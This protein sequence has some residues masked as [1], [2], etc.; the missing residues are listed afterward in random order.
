MLSKG[1]YIV[2]ARPWSQPRLHIGISGGASMTWTD[3]QALSLEFLGLSFQN[4]AHASN[5][6]VCKRRFTVVIQINIA[7]INT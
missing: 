4:G 5:A 7:M 2:I 1:L 6:G 3:A